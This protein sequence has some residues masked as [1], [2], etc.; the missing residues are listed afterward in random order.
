MVRMVLLHQGQG[1]MSGWHMDGMWEQGCLCSV[2]SSRPQCAETFGVGDLN[3]SVSGGH[4][5]F[6]PLVPCGDTGLRGA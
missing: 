5:L 4:I 1:H 3:G 6:I 2:M